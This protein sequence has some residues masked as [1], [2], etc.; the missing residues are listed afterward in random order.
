MFNIKK[1]KYDGWEFEDLL[2]EIKLEY[3]QKSDKLSKYCKKNHLASI[4]GSKDKF[5]VIRKFSCNIIDKKIDLYN[6]KPDNLSEHWGMTLVE[7][8]KHGASSGN[9]ILPDT[10]EYKSIRFDGDTLLIE[11]TDGLTKTNFQELNKLWTL[12]QFSET[13]IQ[14]IYST[15]KNQFNKPEKIQKREDKVVI[16]KEFG[17]LKHD[18][19]LDRYNGAFDLD[20]KNIEISFSN[21]SIDKFDNN[22]IDTEKHLA[23]IS[24]YMDKMIKEMLVLKNESWLEENEEPLKIDTFKKEIGLYSINVYEDSCIELFYKCGDLFWGHE[25]ISNIDTSGKY[26]DSTIIG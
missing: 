23:N 4:N 18:S 21:T 7:I 24:K 5:V 10:I 14:N 9:V 3:E 17:E 1:K 25:I 2:T 20:G 6:C 12:E 26:I 16:S 22:L 8:N 11:E 19:E 15:F 13:E